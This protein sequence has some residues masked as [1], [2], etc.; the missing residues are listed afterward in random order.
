MLEEILKLYKPFI[1]CVETEDYLRI[2]SEQKS[3]VGEKHHILPE[4][5]FPQFSKCDW[6]LVTLSPENHFRCHELLPAMLTGKNKSSMVYAWNM[7]RNRLGDLVDADRYAKLKAEYSKLL[8]E[9]LLVDNPMHRPEVIEKFKLIKR[10][11]ISERL[12]ENNP[13]KLDSVK[14]KKTE[15]WKQ[16]WA[17]PEIRAYRDSTN[18]NKGKKFPERGAKISAAKKGKPNGTKGIKK[19]EGFAEKYLVGENNPMARAVICDGIKF[20]TITAAGKHFGYT[21]QA[22]NYWIKKGRFY[23]EGEEHKQY[24]RTDFRTCRVSINDVEYETLSKA[25]ITYN[26]TPT[27][28]TNWIKSGKAIKLPKEP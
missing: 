1:P 13:S 7:M 20:P 15:K 23:L 4:S 11:D 25:A 5:I 17:D 2:I 10:P 27:T 3:S 21:K 24:V 19:P 26:V 12:R 28:I 16:Y 9:R 6:N 14:Q 8:I 22:V 18:T